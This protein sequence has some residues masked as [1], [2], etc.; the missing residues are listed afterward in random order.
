[1]A[2]IEPA[3]GLD[4]PSR[5]CW[6]DSLG[7]IRAVDAQVIILGDTIGPGRPDVSKRLTRWLLL[8]RI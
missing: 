8:H 1:M 3:A 2:A 5:A 4:T 6:Q 7:H